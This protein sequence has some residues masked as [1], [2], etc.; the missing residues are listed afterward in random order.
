M[1]KL[2]ALFTMLVV[3]AA[4]GGGGRPSTDQIADA[5]KDKDNPLSATASGATDEQIDC[6]AEALHDSDLSDEALQ[7]LVDGDEDYKA[8]SDDEKAAEEAFGDIAKCITP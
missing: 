8:D 5:M 6:I 7:A 3:L 2:V 4:C 1:K